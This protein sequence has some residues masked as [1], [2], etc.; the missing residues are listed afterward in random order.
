MKTLGSKG[1][2]QSIPRRHELMNF[3]EF[4]PHTCKHP[5]RFQIGNQNTTEALGNVGVEHHALLGNRTFPKTVFL[6]VLS[7]TPYLGLDLPGSGAF[8]TVY[9]ILFEFECSRVWER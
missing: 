6:D 4:R 2:Q 1:L 3:L 5:D 8:G 9:T 7:T